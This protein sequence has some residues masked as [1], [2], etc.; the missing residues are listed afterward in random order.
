MAKLTAAQRKSLP[1][2]TFARPDRSYPVPDKTHAANAKARASGAE[3]AGRISK[4]T[5]EKIDAKADRVL[6][7]SDSGKGHWSGH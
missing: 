1:A 6:G 3:H 2:S 4:S 5:E 7:H